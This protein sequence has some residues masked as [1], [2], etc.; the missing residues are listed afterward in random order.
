[1]NNSWIKEEIRGKSRYLSRQTKCKH[2]KLTLGCRRCAK[3]VSEVVN[4]YIIKE[5]I[6][7]HSNSTQNS[8]NQKKYKDQNQKKQV[9]Y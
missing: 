1:M 7:K 9:D 4:N 3:S 5:N 2:N 8:R 6:L